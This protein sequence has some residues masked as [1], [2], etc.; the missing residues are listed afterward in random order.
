MISIP[1][2]Y[3]ELI[4]KITILEIKADRI[5]DPEKHRNVT[6]ELQL[7]RKHRDDQIPAS[8]D[9]EG[10]VQELRTVNEALWVV[11]DDL[12]A[13]EEAQEF[14]DRFVQKARSVYQINDRRARI[15]MDI[16][17]LLKSELLEEKSYGPD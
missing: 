5:S 12:R 15:K 14:S 2:S 10:L 3:G 8:A 16:N 7:L 9:L 4:D 6:R 11:E 17:L 1:V 13:L